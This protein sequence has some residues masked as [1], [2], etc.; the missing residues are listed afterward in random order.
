MQCLLDWSNKYYVLIG[1]LVVFFGLLLWC[2][3][4]RW[5][6]SDKT[7]EIPKKPPKDKSE[8]T[9]DEVAM[10]E[11]GLPELQSVPNPK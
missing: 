5:R 11:R 6:T 1:G 2:I 9:E 4:W 8:P 7:L 10:Q 3:C